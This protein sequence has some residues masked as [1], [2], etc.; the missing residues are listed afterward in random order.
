MFEKFGWKQAKKSPSAQSKS[1]NKRNEK[2]K[3]PPP[4]FSVLLGQKRLP[5]GDKQVK[6]SSRP[7]EGRPRPKATTKDERDFFHRFGYLFPIKFVPRYKS[8][9][10]PPIWLPFSYQICPKV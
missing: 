10:L 3:T 5:K 7:A 2:V 1:K 9:N 8:L 6:N 4:G